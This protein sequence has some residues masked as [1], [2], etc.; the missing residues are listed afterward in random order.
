M[1]QSPVVL[2]C[3]FFFRASLRGRMPHTELADRTSGDPW[4]E[5][6]V[7]HLIYE[8][9]ASPHTVR[10]YRRDVVTFARWGLGA[11]EGCSGPDL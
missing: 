3:E 11:G 4:V 1:N 7:H 5:G 8:R 9:N 10:G 2:C 6:F